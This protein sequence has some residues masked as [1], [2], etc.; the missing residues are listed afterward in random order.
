M[1]NKIYEDDLIYIEFEKSEIPWLKIFPIKKVKELSE[2]DDMT[3]KKLFDVMLLI[4]RQMLLYYNPTK[5]NIASF[6]NYL[7]HLHI[8]VMA[9]FAEDSYFPEPMWGKKQRE[10]RLNLPDF[11][12]FKQ[13]L[14]KQ[15]PLL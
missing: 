8:H 15:L 5:I 12:T 1:E 3:R 4:E 7:P 2:C 13:R 11:E 9:R 14:L 6:G 10:A